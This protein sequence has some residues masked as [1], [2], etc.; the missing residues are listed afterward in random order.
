MKLTEVYVALSADPMVRN[1]TQ[2][3]GLIGDH[4]LYK[5]TITIEDQNSF[6]N[7]VRDYC[8]NADDYINSLRGKGKI[9]AEDDIRF[10]AK[11]C[12]IEDKLKFAGSPH[13]KQR[14]AISG[15]TAKI[16]V[17]AGF[18]ITPEGLDIDGTQFN[19]NLDA[20]VM[21]LQQDEAHFGR[22]TFYL[23]PGLQGRLSTR[24]TKDEVQAKSREVSAQKSTKAP[25]KYADYSRLFLCILRDLATKT[26][27][28]QDSSYVVQRFFFDQLM[29]DLKNESITEEDIRLMVKEIN[30]IDLQPVN[31]NIEAIQ[32]ALPMTTTESGRN[33]LQKM[34]LMAYGFSRKE[35]NEFIEN[36]E[37]GI[38]LSLASGENVDF[39]TTSEVAFGVWQDHITH[40]NTHFGKVDRVLQGIA[41]GED[42]VRGFNFLVNCLTNTGKHVEA[43]QNIPYYSKQ[44]KEFAEIQTHFEGKAEEVAALVKKMQAQAQQQAQQAQEGQQQGNNNI[45]PVEQNKI[46]LDRMKTMEK[47][48]RTNE[49]SQ[50]TAQR[51][52]KEAQGRLQ[53]LQ[54]QVEA[55]IAND[56]KIAKLKQDIEMLKAATKITNQQNGNSQ[57]DAAA[58]PSRE[59]VAGAN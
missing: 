57:P 34:L 46:Y 6:I 11:K 19:F 32:A 18:V 13:F 24:P 5:K 56:E 55:N 7:V 43:L 45:S 35:A 31:I 12:S 30:F 59:V 25:I 51:K 44:F 40:L 28:K 39:Y 8:I 17:A 20:H 53:L 15:E 3:P 29:D 27:D 38:E 33:K 47:I 37:Y 16:G 21:S 10:N 41:G 26:Y 48:Q 42:V 14:T 4:L 23:D 58:A 9:I 22:E 49:Q 2:G 50:A 52:D 36:Q 54:K 1:I